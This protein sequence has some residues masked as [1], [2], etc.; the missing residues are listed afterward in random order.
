VKAL[1]GGHGLDLVLE[2]KLACIEVL[3]SLAFLHCVLL[4]KLE[5]SLALSVH[6]ELSLPQ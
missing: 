1:L 3:A 2:L 5:A 6:V 4:P